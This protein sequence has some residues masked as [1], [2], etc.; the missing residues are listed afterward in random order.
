[1]GSLGVV[2]IPQA[3]QSGAACKL[4]VHLH[5]CGVGYNEIGLQFVL[6]SGFADL[7][8]ENDVVVIFPQVAGLADSYCFNFFGGLGEGRDLDYAKKDAAQ[9]KGIFQMIAD[10]ADL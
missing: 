10:V 8:E 9:M 6:N 7:A 1:M 4:H 5:G 2:Y 3:C